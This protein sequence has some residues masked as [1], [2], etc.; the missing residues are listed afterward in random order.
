LQCF[1]LE[2]NGGELPHQIYFKMKATLHC[3]S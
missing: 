1:F 3:W 2:T